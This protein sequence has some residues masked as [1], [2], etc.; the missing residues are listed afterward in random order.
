M[1]TLFADG[2]RGDDDR[3]PTDTEIRAQAL[4][5]LAAGS[6]TVAATLTWTFHLLSQ[7]PG[8]EG[9]LHEEVDSVLGGRPARW[10]HLSGL[11]FTARVLTEALRLYP[12]VWL[13]MRY[14][15]G[16]MRLV[17]RHLPRGSTLLLSPLAVQRRADIFAGPRDFDP[18]RWLPHRAAAYPR[19]AFVAFGAGAHKCIGDSFGMIEATLTLATITQRWQ[20][21][22]AP[23]VNLRPE[24]F[25][26]AV[27]PR[28]LPM[29]VHARRH[30]RR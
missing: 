19:G 2:G 28:N 15:T 6:H 5:L 27:H 21:R 29:R 14:T 4:S 16:D 12:P 9:R 20:L 1:S 17:S 8:I 7:H 11:A 30:N 24:L 18:D 25:A 10:E 13:L 3:G 22:H 26:L 23:G